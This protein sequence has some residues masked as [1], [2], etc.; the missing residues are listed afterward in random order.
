MSISI[1][2][3]LSNPPKVSPTV[4]ER[5]VTENPQYLL[6]F[7]EHGE[8]PLHIAIQAGNLSLIQKLLQLGAK[9]EQMNRRGVSA[10]RMATMSNRQD[11]TK[12]LVKYSSDLS[13]GFN[14]ILFMPE[15]M[16]KHLN[17]AFIGW[18]FALIACFVIDTVGTYILFSMYVGTIV[19]NV[20][21]LA[22]W[23]FMDCLWA[24]TSTSFFQVCWMQFLE[25]FLPNIICTFVVV[26]MLS[27]WRIFQDYLRIPGYLGDQQETILQSIH[28][29]TFSLLVPILQ[30]NINWLVA[31]VSL[32]RS[33][34]M[35]QFIMSDSATVR[36]NFKDGL[37]TFLPQLAS[38]ELVLQHLLSTKKYIEF[39]TEHPDFL[40]ALIDVLPLSMM[41]KY[42]AVMFDL[43]SANLTYLECNPAGHLEVLA[44]LTIV[45]MGWGPE[46][47]EPYQFI[48]N[49]LLKADSNDLVY[50]SQGY[51]AKRGSYGATIDYDAA[52]KAFTQVKPSN[53]SFY[54]QAQKEAAFL[55]FALAGQ[56]ATEGRQDKWITHFFQGLSHCQAVRSETLVETEHT[57]LAIQQEVQVFVDDLI[58]SR[59]DEDHIYQDV[60]NAGCLSWTT[61]TGEQPILLAA[62]FG[63]WHIVSEIVKK[64]ADTMDRVNYGRVLELAAAAQKDELVV[65]LN[66]RFSFFA[67]TASTASASLQSANFGDGSFLTSP[68]R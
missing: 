57:G 56:Y 62:K 22:S 31:P 51:I 10:L 45:G 17:V 64:H 18:I 16:W 24:S 65:S 6:E 60:L 55:H 7:D 39:F 37:L 9:P 42:K 46:W 11:M 2:D 50:L 36:R 19:G 68:C 26:M 53:M 48:L 20:I 66:Q 29:K 15:T 41:M 4:F 33:H 34:A 3:V 13:S 28:E 43:L 63:H 30:E 8:T 32:F 40:F 25:A 38:S 54:L 52:I 58:A 1:H 35:H 44:K 49:R 27:G 21:P 47:G 59:D 67:S 12:D 23:G 5:F 14:P 61:T